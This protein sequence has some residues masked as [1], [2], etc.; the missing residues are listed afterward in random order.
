VRESD[1]T[2]ANQRSLPTGRRLGLG[3][4]G[5]GRTAQQQAQAGLEKTA[6][7]CDRMGHGITL[8]FAETAGLCENPG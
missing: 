8:W 3:M 5:R 2:R 1:V 4:A 7:N 6:A